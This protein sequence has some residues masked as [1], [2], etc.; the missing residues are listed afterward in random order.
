[1]TNTSTGPLGTYTAMLAEGE[2]KADAEQKQVVLRLERLHTELEKYPEVRGHGS[3]LDIAG[4]RLAQLFRLGKPRT[5][6]PRGVYIWG[7]VGRGKSMIM[8]M[9][10]DTAPVQDKKRIHF[11]EFMQDIQAR[12]RRWRSYDAKERVAAGG[13]ASET[14]PI[15]PVAREIA[16]EATLLCFDEFQVTDIADAMVLGRLFKELMDEGVI[17]VSTSN[18]PPSDLYKDGLNRQLFLPFIAFLEEKLD[19]VTLNGPTDY[20]LDRFKGVETYLVPVDQQTTDQLTAAFFKLTDRNV[21]DRDKVPSETL[22]VQGRDLFVPKAARGVAVFSFKRLCHQPLGAADYLTLARRYHTIILV[23]VPKMGPEMRN[24]AA[25]FRTLID[26]LY[27]NSVK[28]LLNAAV[29]A[30]D[31]YTE[32]S[33][34]F[35][36]ERTVSRLMEMQSV[37]YLSRGHCSRVLQGLADRPAGHSDRVSYDDRDEQDDEPDPV[38]TD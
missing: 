22:S 5:E 14:D 29:P 7:G 8:D 11:H 20:R 4:W 1:M 37:D 32:G 15:R 23:A 19:V 13:R 24:E 27:E 12:L 17:V 26:A 36:F 21:E 9:F 35:E 3:R 30:E 18:R 10:Y 16:A 28:L 6:L 38:A 34:A 25:R 31:L 33:F 2:L